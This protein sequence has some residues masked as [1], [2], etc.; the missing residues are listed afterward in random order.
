MKWIQQGRSIPRYT[1][2]TTLPEVEWTVLHASKMKSTVILLSI[3]IYPFLLFYYPNLVISS[4]Y[5]QAPNPSSVRPIH[6]TNFMP[7]FSCWSSSR[8]ERC[9]EL[10]SE[11]E[12]TAVDQKVVAQGASV[13][14]PWG[15]RKMLESKLL[16]WLYYW[17][18]LSLSLI[19]ILGNSSD[20]IVL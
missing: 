10:S 20:S 13:L 5:K 16:V 6:G 15:L 18:L 9:C 17:M 8:L 1:M 2:G 14:G 4:S 11:Q 7:S 3:Q 12:A 19:L